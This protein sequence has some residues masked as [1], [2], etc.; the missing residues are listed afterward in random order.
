MYGQPLIA[1]GAVYCR[2]LVARYAAYPR[3]VRAIVLTDSKQRDRRR[4]EVSNKMAGPG[5]AYRIKDQ[6][7]LHANS[8]LQRRRRYMSL[9]YGLSNRPVSPPIR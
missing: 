8:W 5:W 4:L 2:P 9:S 7:N 3:L 1:V 6:L